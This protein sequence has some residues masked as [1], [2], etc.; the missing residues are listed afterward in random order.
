MTPR[1]AFNRQQ[2]ALYDRFTQFTLIAAREAIAQSGLSFSG[3][4]AAQS[5]VVLGNSGGG[6]TTSDENYRASTKTART[7]CIPLSCP[8]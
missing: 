4:L 3:E 2:M 8:S 1:R 7:G 5:G 6:M